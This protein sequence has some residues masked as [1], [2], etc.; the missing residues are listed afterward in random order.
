[1]A[2]CGK[3]LG[4][5]GERGRHAG[6]G[7]GE[8]GGMKRFPESLA[9]SPQRHPSMLPGTALAVL[10]ATMLVL[11]GTSR[12]FGYERTSICVSSTSG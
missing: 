4:A 2:D 9:P 8:D 6:E 5:A 7:S 10:A 11:L 3:S 1:M 12:L